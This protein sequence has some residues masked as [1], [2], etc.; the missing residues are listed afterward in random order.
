M[1]IGCW[2]VRHG[3]TPAEALARVSEG[4][5]SM[6]KRARMRNR[7][8]PESADQIRVVEEWESGA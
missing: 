8:S 2:L 1:T 5:D 7:T 6:Q 3:H 4:F